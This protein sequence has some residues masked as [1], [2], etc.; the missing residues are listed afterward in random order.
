VI[1][2]LANEPHPVVG[3]ILAVLAIRM[4]AAWFALLAIAWTFGVTSWSGL[5]RPIGP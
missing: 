4:R 1:G 5:F 3:A 2:G